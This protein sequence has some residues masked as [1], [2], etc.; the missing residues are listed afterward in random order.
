[1]VTPALGREMTNHLTS[2]YPVSQRRACR[3]VGIDRATVR[4]QPQ[5]KAEIVQLAATIEKRLVA[6]AAIRPRF[7]YRRL[8]V[9]LRREGYLVNHKRVYRLYQQSHLALRRKGR[10]CLAALRRIPRAAP[11]RANQIWAIDF[12][13]DTLA[14]GRKFRTLNV[15]DVYT[16]E[17]RALEVD[18]SLAG[19][20]VVRVLERLG[21][22]HGLPEQIMLDN[23]PEFASKVLDTWA[24]AHQVHLDFI[25]PGKPTDNGYIESFNG[26]FRDECLNCHWFTSLA[27]AR[28]LIEAWR[29]DYNHARPHSALRQL[30]P[31]D[32]AK[33]SIVFDPSTLIPAG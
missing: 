2:H 4:Y 17:C 24:Y 10:K 12:M 8:S 5:R 14:N 13:Q 31:A 6:L 33:R 32:F 23:G 1:M 3:V 29:C 26:K 21:E 18:T 19:A 28:S 30:T 16:R 27:D 25:R 9:L 22:A 15:V 20:R 11:V 7:G